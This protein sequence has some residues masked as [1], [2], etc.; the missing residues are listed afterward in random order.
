MQT[1]ASKRFVSY[2]PALG[3][4]DFDST[5]ESD[6]CESSFLSGIAGERIYDGQACAVDWV[7]VG[8]ESGPGARPFDVQ[9]AR[10]V[11]AQCKAAG[12]A[13]FVKQLGANVRQPGPDGNPGIIQWQFNNPKGCDMSEWPED[14]RVREFPD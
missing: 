11:I 8:G 9:W 4:V 6:P 2:E 12:V 3:P 1:P 13:C 5:H 7:I 14:L 10:D